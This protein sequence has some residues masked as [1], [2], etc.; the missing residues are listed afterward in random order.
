MTTEE[1]AKEFAKN[2]GCEEG[3]WLWKMMANFHN[4]QPPNLDLKCDC[5]GLIA[6]KKCG[7]EKNLDAGF[8]GRMA[9]K[10]KQRAEQA[11]NQLTQLTKENQELRDRLKIDGCVHDL[12]GIDQIHSK[13]RKCK[14]IFED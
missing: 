2:L 11:E 12:Y 10:N 1:K 5:S 9:A 8:W 4:S 6:C 13:C 7:E 3:L 14:A